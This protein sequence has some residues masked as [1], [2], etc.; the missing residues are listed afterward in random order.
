M[1]LSEQN[2]NLLRMNPPPVPGGGPE[3]YC[4]EDEVDDAA[5]AGAAAT[6]DAKASGSTAA[7][8]VANTAAAVVQHLD[9]AAVSRLQS[10]RSINRNISTLRSI[11]KAGRS[12]GIFDYLKWSISCMLT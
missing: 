2:F 6:A 4:D 3:D 1:S 9:K 8:T 5:A 7:L 10:E 11:P 12:S